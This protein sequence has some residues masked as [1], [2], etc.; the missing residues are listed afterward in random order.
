MQIN[1]WNKINIKMNE[2][3]HTKLILLLFSEI[4]SIFLINR[5]MVNLYKNFGKK[6]QKLIYYKNK[7]IF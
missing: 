1:S 5:K 3:Y 6:Y 4:I 7:I 2:K